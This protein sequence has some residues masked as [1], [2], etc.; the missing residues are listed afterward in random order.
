MSN[1]LYKCVIFG[2]LLRIGLSAEIYNLF[3]PY[4]QEGGDPI[5]KIH[6]SSY[7]LLLV[8]FCNCLG[9]SN[10]HD[11]P[12]SNL[13]TPVRAWLGSLWLIAVVN[14]LRFGTSGTAYLVD[15]LIVPASV[16]LMTVHMTTEQR[17]AATNLFLNIIVVNS[18]LAIAEFIGNFHLIP[19]SQEW[20]LDYFRSTAL[21]GHPLV[22]AL[23]T[24]STAPFV[25]LSKWSPTK[26]TISLF[27]MYTALL[28]F[29]GRSAF[30]IGL[31][32]FFVPT[33]AVGIRDFF[34]GRISVQTFLSGYLKLIIGLAFIW[35]ICFN[36]DMGSRIRDLG[37]Y[38]DS[39]AVRISSFSV[40]EDLTT[41]ELWSG[42]DNSQY[43]LI[44]EGNPELSIIEN[45]W[46][47]MVVTF[48]IPL[49]VLFCITFAWTFV[50]LA[51]SQPAYYV[52]AL[53]TFV[54]VASTNN[55]LSTKTCSLLIFIVLAAAS[56]SDQE[57]TR[58]IPNQR[59]GNLR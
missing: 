11:A 30:A 21:F 14:L 57:T 56:R 22:N 45:F 26:K 9:V 40:F 15:T 29:G 53:L 55:S 35:Y 33:I 24:S 12:R 39:A 28:S 1:A 54:T 44:R 10:T 3:V 4:S 17:R 19:Q 59:N 7:W 49:F 6:P 43:E 34:Q 16:L 25:A 8:F 27:L 58:A 13:T 48:G 32:L 5:F 38:D 47:N 18:A 23:I 36:T 20:S 41:D 42:I 31:V 52:S 2:V 50:N 37:I 51:R 46:I